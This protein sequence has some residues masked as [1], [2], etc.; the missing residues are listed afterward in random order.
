MRDLGGNYQRNNF[1]MT[2]D[3]FRENQ[4]KLE[5]EMKL[6]EERKTKE[7]ESARFSSFPGIS[8]FSRFRR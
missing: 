5:E 4:R 8:S 1:V 3:L 7:K 6:E 2:V